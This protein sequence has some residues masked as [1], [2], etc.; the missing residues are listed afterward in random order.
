MDI[1][2]KRQ[3][4]RWDTSL[5]LLFKRANASKDEHQGWEGLIQNICE[6]G[7]FF[8]CPEC[9]TQDL[10]VDC[11]LDVIIVLLSQPNERA[12]NRYIKTKGSIVRIYKDM[13][14]PQTSGVALKFHEGVNSLIFC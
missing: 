11:I 10:D 1:V 7:L 3:E 4:P 8:I 2:D 5:P 13:E 6:A 12:S 9:S 14:A